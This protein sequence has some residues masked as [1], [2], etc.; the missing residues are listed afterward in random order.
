MKKLLLVCVALGAIQAMAADWGGEE[1]KIAG[2][3]ALD[4]F[5]AE[6]PDDFPLVTGYTVKLKA[7]KTSADVSVT[8][9]KEGKEL[10]DKFFCHTHGTEIDCH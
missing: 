10:V 5:K 9:K 7:T 6:Y 8:Y 2:N 1:L 4:L 3:A